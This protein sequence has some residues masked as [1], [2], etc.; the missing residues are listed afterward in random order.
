MKECEEAIK[1]ATEVLRDHPSCYEAF[2]ARGNL[3]EAFLTYQRQ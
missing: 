1:L 3:D 2:H